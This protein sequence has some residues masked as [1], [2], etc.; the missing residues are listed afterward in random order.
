M[1]PKWNCMKRNGIRH[2]DKQTS[3]RERK[4]SEG[5]IWTISLLIY[6]SLSAICGIQYVWKIVGTREVHVRY[7]LRFVEWD[8]CNSLTATRICFHCLCWIGACA[9][10]NSRSE[11]KWKTGIARNHDLIGHCAQ[12]TE[13]S[14][15]RMHVFLID[16][17][18]CPRKSIYIIVKRFKWLSMRSSFSLLAWTIC[19]RWIYTSIDSYIAGKKQR[20][21]VW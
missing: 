8:A 2:W 17:Q 14:M 7:F 18:F 3:E 12:V 19:S 6:L 10:G 4:R 9:P 5:K 16:F 11:F 15:E 1:Q 13:F 20:R 21:E